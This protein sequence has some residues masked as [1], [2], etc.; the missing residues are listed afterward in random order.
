MVIESNLYY[1]IGFLDDVSFPISDSRKED[2][3][4]DFER[5]FLQELREMKLLISDKDTSDQHKR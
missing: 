1:I 5:E 4:A 3:D 2:L